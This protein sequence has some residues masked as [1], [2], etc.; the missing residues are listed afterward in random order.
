MTEKRFTSRTA[1]SIILEQRID[2]KRNPSSNQV[3][4]KRNCHVTFRGVE[5]FVYM[6]MDEGISESHLER[7]TEFR[8]IFFPSTAL[9]QNVELASFANAEV[10][11][12]RLTIWS[13]VFK[14]TN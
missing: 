3:P 2:L 10:A 1:K 12:Q 9:S 11:P 7:Y 6:G 14:L 4:L 8:C 5:K 13:K